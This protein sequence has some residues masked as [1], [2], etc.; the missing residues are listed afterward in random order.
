LNTLRAQG[1]DEGQGYLFS[2]ALNALKFL[3]FYGA[4]RDLAKSVGKP[5][6]VKAAA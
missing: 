5:I 6:L 3:A 4:Q 1:V 2:P